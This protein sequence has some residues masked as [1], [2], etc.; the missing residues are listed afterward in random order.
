MV[1]WF[2][3]HC[4]F[5]YRVNVDLN[6][7]LDKIKFYS[8]N[9]QDIVIL[10]SVYNFTYLLFINIV[11]GHF[12]VCFTIAVL[13]SLVTLFAIVWV[14]LRRITNEEEDKLEREHELV[15]K[16]LR[17]E[18]L[19]VHKTKIKNK[20]LMKAGCLPPE[21]VEKT[22]VVDHDDPHL[23]LKKDFGEVKE[24]HFNYIECDDPRKKIR[25]QP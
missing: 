19:K 11:K 1:A 12:V 16:K 9:K 21:Q 7:R 8:F 2:H 25:G 18:Y 24:V 15:R 17:D 10:L 13:L 23:S 20:L 3:R 22:I 4:D 6:S 14:D 5:L